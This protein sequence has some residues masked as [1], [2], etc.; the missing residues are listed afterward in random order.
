MINNIHG[1]NHALPAQGPDPVARPENAAPAEAAR[2]GDV[3]EISTAARLAAAVQELPDVR[4]DLVARVKAEIEAGTYETPDRIEV[5]V[6][7]LMEDLGA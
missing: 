1:V 5:A 6:A 7:R 4:A 2:T 3:I